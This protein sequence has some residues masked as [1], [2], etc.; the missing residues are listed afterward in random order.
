MLRIFSFF[1][2]QILAEVE[3]EFDSQ[4]VSQ[5]QSRKTTSSAL[6]GEEI[7]NLT[8]GKD[9]AQVMEEALDPSSLEVWR[10]PG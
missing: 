2:A 6:R 5:K 4:A 7:R 8:S 3:R 10:K 9:I 1:F